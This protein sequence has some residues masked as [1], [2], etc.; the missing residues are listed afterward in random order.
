[1]GAGCLGKRVGKKRPADATAASSN[2]DVD[3]ED[4]GEVIDVSP[5]FAEILAEVD[6]HKS[7]LGGLCHF[8][9]RPFIE[10]K[11]KAKDLATAYSD[12][13]YVYLE[14]L[15]LGRL[16][17][18]LEEIVG[19]NNGQEFN[20]NPGVQLLER[21]CGMTMHASRPGSNH[22]LRTAPAC[23]LEAY[24]VAQKTHSMSKFFK[25]AFDRKADPCLEGR[26]DRLMKFIETRGA[27]LDPGMPPW[28]DVSL[29]ALPQ[30]SSPQ[31]I[32]GEHLR[33]FVA[34]CTWAWSRQVG[35][36]YDRA[37]EIR[38]DDEHSYG[39]V[40][41]CNASRFRSSMV[42]R[43]VASD[44]CLAKWE[45]STKSDEPKWIPY[46]V[47]VSDLIEEAWQKSVPSVEVRLGPKSWKYTIDFS[48]NVQRNP[49]T[50]QER[51][52]RRGNRLPSERAGKLSLGEL[53]TQIFFF[54]ELA[55]LPPSPALD[56]D[57]PP[58]PLPPTSVVVPFSSERGVVELQ[59]D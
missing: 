43:S 15:G 14:V 53:D 7:D 36:T 17:S 40:Q 22:M 2:G 52:L 5:L 3:T 35:V 44:A 16:H 37:K 58:T 1:M 25:E 27:S 19:K 42:S 31:D 10:Q 56:D 59:V 24:Q 51:S 23:L 11:V 38:F 57:D 32:V 49:K 34:E 29:K 33:V 54:V 41:L 21:V 4:F 28:E 13:E 55:T 12:Y 20:K 18:R 45:S 8:K 26:V 48:Q 30:N 9:Q 46:D 50:G 47:D 39:F 6:R